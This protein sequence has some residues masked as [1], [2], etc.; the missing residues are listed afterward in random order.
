MRCDIARNVGYLLIGAGAGALG[1]MFAIE[2]TVRKEYEESS[3][4][5]RRAMELSRVHQMQAEVPVQLEGDLLEA[6]RT[7]RDAHMAQAEA[8][9]KAEPQ[10]EIGP[11]GLASSGGELTREESDDDPPEYINH[12][13]K[14][15]EAAETPVDMF[16]EG[17]V[18]DYGVSYIEEDEFYEEDGRFKGQIT[19]VLEGNGATFFM[20]GLQIHDWDERVGDSILVDFYRLVPPDVPPVLYIRNH[21]RDEDYEVTRE[22]P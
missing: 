6:A 7:I 15:L 18:N 20:D 4:A 2:K 9:E 5:F 1:G 19:L 10:V 16:V 17:G 22:I 14:A 8:M 3:A 13:A 12:Y 21:K 11:P